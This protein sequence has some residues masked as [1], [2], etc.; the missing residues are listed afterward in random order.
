[1]ISLDDFADA[2]KDFGALVVF[3]TQET[4]AMVDTPDGMGSVGGFDV[5]AGSCQLTYSTG[6]LDIDEADEVTVD[7]KPYVVRDVRAITD[8]QL[9]VATVKAL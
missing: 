5:V 1:M 6:E 8:G 3:G 7:G 4:Y 2:F 9:T